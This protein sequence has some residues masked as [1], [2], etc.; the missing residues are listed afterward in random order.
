MV[1]QDLEHGIDRELDFNL[2]WMDSEQKRLHLVA[3]L[4]SG[5]NSDFYR[6]NIRRRWNEAKKG[7]DRKARKAA[8]TTGRNL[9]RRTTG[10]G[11]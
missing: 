1:W 3:A 4:N 6:N 8:D 7:Y 2:P 10:R 9:L 5:L 11:T